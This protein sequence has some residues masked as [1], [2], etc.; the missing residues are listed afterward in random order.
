MA[1]GR[2]VRGGGAARFLS[3]AAALAALGTFPCQAEPD[4]A[5][6]RRAV[7]G[8]ASRY[9]DRHHGRRTASGDVFRIERLTAAHRTLPLG[10]VARITNLD[11]GRSVEVVIN[12]RGPALVGRLID[13]SAAA[14]TVLGMRTRGLA[15]VAILPLGD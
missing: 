10:S 5:V 14:A 6:T 12:D 7:V 4:G 9:G 2:W 3:A 15:R 8:I 1:T 11:N 13:V